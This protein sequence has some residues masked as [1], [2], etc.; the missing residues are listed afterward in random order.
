MIAAARHCLHR[1][2]DFDGRT[3]RELYMPFAHMVTGGMVLG[4]VL[5]AMQMGSTFSSGLGGVQG[6]G[7]G[8]VRVV[9]VL[10]LLIVLGGTALLAAATVRRLH[11][12]G[13][14]GWWY[15]AV[16]ASVGLTFLS[17]LV[18]SQGFGANLAIA[19]VMRL[20][21]SVL[22]L[23]VPAQFVFLRI[24]GDP[25]PNRY[26]PPFVPEEEPLGD[27]P[28]YHAESA[29]ARI[30]AL[31]AERARKKPQQLSRPV[32]APGFGRRRVPP[33]TDS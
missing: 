25:G 20:T 18:A 17:I 11:D 24:K 5:L 21:A 10:L 22:F 12:T 9:V 7:G 6:G 3:P 1:L 4:V 19:L 32:A 16:P 8:E 33:S 28:G 15:G 29:D 2:W 14:S 31:L 27:G 13:R 26:G 30:A 23:A